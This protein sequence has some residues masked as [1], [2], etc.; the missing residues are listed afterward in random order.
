MLATTCDQIMSVNTA[1]QELCIFFGEAGPKLGKVSGVSS[2]LAAGSEVFH[3]D[4]VYDELFNVG[5]WDLNDAD[6]TFRGAIAVRACEVRVSFMMVQEAQRTAGL[7][8][9][10]TDFHLSTELEDESVA[11]GISFALA[12]N[13]RACVSFFHN[14][15]LLANLSK[16]QQPLQALQSKLSCEFRKISH[17]CVNRQQS[18]DWF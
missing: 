11:V 10:N 15:L 4:K 9:A 6:I 3:T 5:G 18:L 7:R 8:V 13:L 12:I 14:E 17:R 16:T 2:S 1:R